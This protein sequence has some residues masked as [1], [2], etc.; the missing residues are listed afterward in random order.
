MLA[1]CPISTTTATFVGL[2]ANSVHAFYLTY[3][4]SDGCSDAREAVSRTAGNGRRPQGVR[5][6]AEDQ[7]TLSLAWAPAALARY[8]Y[9]IQYSTPTAQGLSRV[10][11]STRSTNNAV[12][13]TKPTVGALL[14]YRVRGCLITGCTDYSDIAE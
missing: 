13:L 5:A 12:Q 9:E 14:G 4:N 2:R 3:R 11:F 1:S 8:V 6:A 10:T 7:S